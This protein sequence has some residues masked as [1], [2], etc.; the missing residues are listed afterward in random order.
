[1]FGIRLEKNGEKLF[2]T[3][4]YYWDDFIDYE[5]LQVTI[6]HIWLPPR[7]QKKLN[8]SITFPVLVPPPFMDGWVI[9]SATN[10]KIDPVAIGISQMYA[11]I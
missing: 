4:G 8:F 7:K 1:M 11:Y 2:S 5:Y 6:V 10:L 3:I 9:I